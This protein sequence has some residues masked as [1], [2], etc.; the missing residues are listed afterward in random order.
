MT[1]LSLAA[2][3]GMWW[4]VMPRLWR[5]EPVLRRDLLQMLR[6]LPGS[7]ATSR[8]ILR[9]L[10]LVIA[11][12]TIA[13]LPTLAVVLLDLVGVGDVPWLKRSLLG[14]ALV[15]IA[16][17]WVLTPMV[18]CLNV[19]KS[20]VSPQLWHEWGALRAWR[21]ARHLRRAYR[22][23]GRQVRGDRGAGHQ[24]RPTESVPL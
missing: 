21:R 23:A 10:P 9:A 7:A 19:P 2:F 1:V 3:A 22:S 20:V 15:G 5:N 8:G 14:L 24:P 12:T 13:A 6:P 17:A 11:T 4:S 16:L 18:V